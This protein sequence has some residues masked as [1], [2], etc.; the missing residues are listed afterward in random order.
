[1]LFL[2]DMHLSERLCDW[3]QAAGHHAIH[4]RRL[5]FNEMPDN[6]ILALAIAEDRGPLQ[7]TA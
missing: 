2:V 4:L 1:L 6:E 7:R 5:G 3:L